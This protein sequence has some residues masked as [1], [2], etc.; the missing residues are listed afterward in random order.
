VLDRAGQLLH[1]AT[2]RPSSDVDCA[3]SS[4]PHSTRH[5]RG[6][7]RANLGPAAPMG[8]RRRE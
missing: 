2:S 8:Q 6:A 4:L 1:A 5:D 3:G 7:G